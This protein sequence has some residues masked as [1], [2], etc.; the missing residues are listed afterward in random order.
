MGMK[1]AG[2]HSFIRLKLNNRGVS[3]VGVLAASVVAIVV[4]G[5][6]VQGVVSMKTS[7]QRVFVQGMLDQMHLLAIQKVSNYKNSRTGESLLPLLPQNIQDCLAGRGTNCA[8]SG[9][10]VPFTG[11]KDL[12]G[13]LDLNANLCTSDCPVQRKSSYKVSCSSTTRCDY[14]EFNVRTEFRGNKKIFGNMADRDSKVRISGTSISGQKS[15]DFS[16]IRQG[17]ILTGI[18]YEHQKAICGGL[19]TG[20]ISSCGAGAPNYES[21]IL[22]FGV[23]PGSSACANPAGYQPVVSGCGGGVGSAS[24]SNSLSGCSSS[25]SNVV[26]T[27][28]QT[29]QNVSAPAPSSLAA[30]NSA[31]MDMGTRAVS[32]CWIGGQQ[33]SGHGGTGTASWN[34]GCTSPMVG[35]HY[36]EVDQVCIDGG[37]QNISS[38]RDGTYTCA[39]PVPP[40][41]QNGAQPGSSQPGLGLSHNPG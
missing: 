16:C 33:V 18:D 23:I 4:V 34:I 7:E 1:V 21:P 19:P 8:S 10:E 36:R 39:L 28:S 32:N 27:G 2:L 17:G 30:Q 11:D 9:T 6:L 14:V 20:S 12:S 26:Y 13:G 31:N 29:L 41:N 5:G 35:V 40:Q 3:L 38:E 37:L 25:N 24:S 22:K 15:I